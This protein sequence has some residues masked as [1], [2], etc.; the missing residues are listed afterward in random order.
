MKITKPSELPDRQQFEF[1]L[2]CKLGY[3]RSNNI[4]DALVEYLG[5]V[6]PFYENY[7]GDDPVILKSKHDMKDVVIEAA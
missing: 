7:D 2:F 1:V 5:S 6:K 3:G 4:K